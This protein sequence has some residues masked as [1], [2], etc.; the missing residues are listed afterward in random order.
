MNTTATKHLHY[1]KC[2]DCLSPMATEERLVKYECFCGG[3]VEYMGAVKADGHV[4]DEQS[5][6][7][8][9]TLCTDATGPNCSCSCGG[10]NHGQHMRADI[11]VDLDRGVAILT[12]PDKDKALKVV[13]EYR[14]ACAAAEAR[15]MAV[16]GKAREAIKAGV[17]IE[18]GAWEGAFYGW[19]SIRQAAGGKTVAGRIKK[20]N[21]LTF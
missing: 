18:R 11:K 19:K 10:Q 8:C 6:T 20:L 3:Q 16:H 14:A 17:W 9:N 4:H 1:Y 12:P 5:Q 7:P 13:A 2:R 21:G 15:F